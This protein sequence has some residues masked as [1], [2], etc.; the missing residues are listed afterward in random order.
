MTNSMIE[1]FSHWPEWAEDA[2]GF[3]WKNEINFDN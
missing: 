2:K 1:G 3:D